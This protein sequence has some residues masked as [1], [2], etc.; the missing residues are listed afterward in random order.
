MR[1]ASLALFLAV[2]AA[3]GTPAPAPTTSAGSCD[4]SV[5]TLPGKTFVELEIQGD[6]SE[7]P[8]PQ[9]RVKF[10]KDGGTITAAYT[11]KN[12]LHSYAYT[13]TPSGR[14]G[15]LKCATKPFFDRA[16]LALEVHKEGS[17][18]PAK[19]AEMG[20]EGS[21]DDV[22]AGIKQAQ[23]SYAK[24]KE[25]KASI[26][27]ESGADAAERAWKNFTITN[28]NV[29]NTLQ[30]LIYAKIDTKRCRIQIDDMFATIYEGARKEDFNPVGSNAFVA[31]DD[32]LLFADCTNERALV[33]L[34]SAEPP[35]ADLSKIPPVREFKTGQEVHYHYVGNDALKAEDGCTYAMD[36][37]ANWTP[38]GKAVPAE[39]VDGKVNWHATHTWAADDLKYIGAEA[40]RPLFGG[41][42]HVTRHKV[43]GGK[44]EVI[45][46]LCYATRVAKE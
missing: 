30:G 17:C 36:L 32:E 7:K 9:A 41:F 35:P 20:F 27:K 1:L 26:L 40:G 28:N 5:E 23:E 34:E 2:A 22:A 33:D 38:A 15:E 45:D 11:V 43:C 37:W 39:V 46:N 6:G 24:A 21:S 18:T 16:C 13:C 25:Q 12:G 19:L 44:D 4:L 8:N 42:M 3:C 14:D 29:A 31:S 10:A